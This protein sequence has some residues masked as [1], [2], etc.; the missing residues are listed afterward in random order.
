MENDWVLLFGLLAAA[1]RAVYLLHG[2]RDELR[3]IRSSLKM[4][5]T[6]S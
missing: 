1:G 4:S 3:L 2:I 5:E 6:D